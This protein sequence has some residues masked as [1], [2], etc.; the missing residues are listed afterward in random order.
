V[1]DLLLA[2]GLE[3]SV[4]VAGSTLLDVNI[5]ESRCRSERQDGERSDSVGDQ[6]D[7]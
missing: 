2:L 3:T 7:C 5:R 1:F 4:E 6:H